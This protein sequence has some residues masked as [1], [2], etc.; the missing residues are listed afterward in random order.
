[1]RIQRQIIP[2]E[3]VLLGSA[4]SLSVVDQDFQ[5]LEHA[6][7]ATQ[8]DAYKLTIKTPMPG[9]VIIR[10]QSTNHQMMLEVRS[11]SLG[12]LAF[13]PSRLID[14]VE[15]RVV[16]VHNDLD[17]VTYD[18]CA[19]TRSLRWKPPSFSTIDLF[20]CDPWT[21]HLHQGTRIVFRDDSLPNR[22]VINME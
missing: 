16:A 4:P 20:D 2:L 3:L 14:L 7:C 13:N 1:M 19:V 9:K 21:Y 6:L 22:S 12:G 10:L 5:P 17:K 11:M 18:S 15:H 8:H